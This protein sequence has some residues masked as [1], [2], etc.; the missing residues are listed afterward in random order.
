MKEPAAM[1]D[2][3]LSGELNEAMVELQEALERAAA[4]SARI[5]SLLPDVSRISAVFQELESVFE[6]GRRSGATEAAHPRPTL[7]VTPPTPKRTKRAQPLAEAQ[8]PEPLADE[9]RVELPAAPQPETSTLPDDTLL[10]PLGELASVAAPESNEPTV[11]FRLEFESNP[12]PLDL[13]AVDE[14]VSQHPFVR[15][16]AL[17]DYDGRRATLKVW[18]SPAVTAAE[19]QE[20]LTTRA[21]EMGNGSDV[22]IVTLEDVA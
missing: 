3:D 14:A 18:V 13:R 5:Q 7:V 22:S 19:V 12:G 6:A 8:V 2:Q 4:A 17:L 21:A 15:D 11:T 1:T 16:V 10:A 9:W 20:S